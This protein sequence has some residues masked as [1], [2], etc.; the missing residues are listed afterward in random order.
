MCRGDTDLQ[1]Y[2]GDY[3]DLA[4]FATHMR[5]IADFKGVDLLLMYAHKLSSIAAPHGPADQ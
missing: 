5:A 2:S 1:N 3:G 4:S